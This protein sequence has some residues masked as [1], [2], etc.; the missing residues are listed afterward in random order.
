MFKLI[1]CMEVEKLEWVE[2]THIESVHNKHPIEV[3]GLRVIRFNHMES[4]FLKSK[5]D[6]HIMEWLLFC[7]KRKIDPI[8][9]P[10]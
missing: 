8:Q 2:H 1:A 5:Y 9:P 10:T 4:E 3:G 7:S 6:F